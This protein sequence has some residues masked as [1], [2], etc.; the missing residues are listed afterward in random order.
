MIK[1]KKEKDRY[2]HKCKRKGGL[3]KKKKVMR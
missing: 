1:K 2:A 3:N